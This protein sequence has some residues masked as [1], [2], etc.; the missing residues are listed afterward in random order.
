MEGFIGCE[1]G[2]CFGDDFF[3]S[4]KTRMRKLEELFGCLLVL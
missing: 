2:G 3:V 4:L 1:M